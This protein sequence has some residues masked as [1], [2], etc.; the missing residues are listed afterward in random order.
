MNLLAH[1]YLSGDDRLLLLGNFIGD[2]VKGKAYENYP[3]GIRKGILAHRFIDSFTD[4]HPLGKEARVLIRPFAGKFA[5]VVLDLLYDHFLAREWARFHF[6]PL[7]QYALQ[8]YQ[9]LGEYSDWMPQRIQKM[10]RYMSRED[11][12]T[13]YAT[14]EGIQRAMRGLS[15]RSEYPFDPVQSLAVLNDHEKELHEI[16]LRFF[17]L[18]EKKLVEWKRAVEDS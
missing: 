12:L 15:K 6:L 11:W 17:P 8:V 7:D 1:I 18:M 16:F 9:I 2:A 3:P 5:P 10:Y 13:G 4:D 14:K